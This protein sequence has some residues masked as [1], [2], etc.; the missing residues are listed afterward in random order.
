MKKIVA[1][2]VLS[3]VAAYNVQADTSLVGTWKYVDMA[4][5][6]GV[7]A[8]PSSS[9][10]STK[11]TGSASITSSLID[12]TFNIDMKADKPAADKLNA[13]IVKARA[14][15]EALPDSADKT[16]ALKQVVESEKAIVMLRSGFNCHAR[17]VVDYS[18]H[19]NM[20]ESDLIKESSNCPGWTPSKERKS[21]SE[22]HLSNDV[23][24]VADAAPVKEDGNTCPKGDYI[25]NIFS[26][27][28]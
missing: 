19:G 8:S 1:V 27:V 5:K 12:F 9:P 26:R 22:F 23:L 16:N 11:F 3:F 6:S 20:I 17:V 2:C 4:C 25:I 21:T 15:I 28:R 10:A 24:L 13:D 18:T 14:Q 7:K